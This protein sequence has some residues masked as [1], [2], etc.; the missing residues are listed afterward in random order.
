VEIK[1][2]RNFY[3]EKTN[4]KLILISSIWDEVK[5]PNFLINLCWETELTW[6]QSKAEILLR[7]FLLEGSILSS[8]VQ[9]KNYV[10]SQLLAL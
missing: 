9:M 1:I 7:P 3:E 10:S 8:K 6:K 2:K 5:L 4:D